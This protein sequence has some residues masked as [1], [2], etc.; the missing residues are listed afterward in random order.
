MANIASILKSEI[1][2]VARKE[3][4]GELQSL[5]KA[6]AAYRSDIASLK[7]RA[8]ALEQQLKRLG[9]SGARTAQP[10]E[11]ER[12]GQGLRFSAKGLAAQRRRL[13]LSAEACGALVGASGQSVYKW[14]SGKIRPR[15]RHLAGIAALRKMGKREAA[16]RLQALGG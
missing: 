2:R 9:K 14:E 15:A 3:V 1:A 11:S 12:P 7:R 16:A 13:G 5:K 10:D 6:A 8:S 4:R